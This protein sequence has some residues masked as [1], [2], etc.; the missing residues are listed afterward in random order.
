MRLR[1]P[2]LIRFVLFGCFAFGLAALGAEIQCVVKNK[3]VNTVDPRLFGSFMERPSW[4]EIGPEGALVPGT[5]RLQPGVIELLRGMHIPIVRFP[6][7]TDAD[8]LDW[9][10]MVSNVPGRDA[11]RPMSAGHEGDMV[12]NNFGYDEFLRLSAELGWQDILVVNFRAGLLQQLPLNEAAQRAASLVAYCNGPL[13]GKLP[14]GM[15]D[16]PAIRALNGHPAPYNVKYWQIGNETWFFKNKM[17]ELAP[18]HADRYYADCLLTYARAML[19]VDTNIEFIA[20]G[21]DGGQ[22]AQADMPDKIRHL[23]FHAYQPWAIKEV[24]RNHQPVPFSKLSSAEIWNAWVATPG[25]DRNGLAVFNNELLT[26]ARQQHFK[27]AVTE[28]NW[29]GWWDPPHAAMTSSF[30]KAVGAA[31][32]VHALMRSSDSIDIACQSMLVGMGWK[33]HAIGADPT[34]QTPPYYMPTGQLMALYA[35]HHGPRLL[36]LETFGIPTYKQP[37]KMGDIEPCDKVACLDV[38]ATADDK[39]LYLHII[40]RS[41]EKNLTLSVDA[42]D[43]GRLAGTARRF[44]LTGRLKDRPEGDESRQISRITQSDFPLVAGKLS[45]PVPARSVSCVEIPL[46]P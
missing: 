21:V 34:A 33:I 4:G 23:V 5:D 39:T 32:F 28:W 14:P 1:L 41:F 11:S 37:F 15:P 22:L 24:E 29:N 10:D 45:L 9:R 6:G 26:L 40:N 17:E 35:A 30:A 42:T 7:G 16:W 13:G 2:L 20:D 8:F 43:F 18:G 44:S 46:A 25:F 3:T 38:L 31:G 19:A 36:A 27:V 12:S